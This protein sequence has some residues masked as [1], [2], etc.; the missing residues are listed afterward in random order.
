[1]VTKKFKRSAVQLEHMPVSVG[2]LSARFDQDERD[3]LDQAAKADERSA[4]LIVRRVMR[5][6]LKVQGFLK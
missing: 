5:D 3:A 1:M 6:R 4:P 2:P